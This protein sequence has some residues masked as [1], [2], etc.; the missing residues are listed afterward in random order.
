VLAEPPLVVQVRG[1]HDRLV[2][3]EDSRDLEGMPTSAQMAV[4]RATHDDV[5]AV[6]DEPEDYPGERYNILRDVIIGNVEPTDPPALPPSERAVTAVAFLLHGIRAGIG[7]WVTRLGGKLQGPGANVLV[8]PSYGY[9]S[10]YNFAI[11][12]GHRCMTD[13][14]HEPVAPDPAEQA[15]T[16]LTLG[17]GSMSPGSY[18]RSSIASDVRVLAVEAFDEPVQA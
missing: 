15:A 9:L 8:A 6:E 2:E 3:R 14:R 10:A 1:G 16:A 11:P 5:M 4:P 17:R 18:T 7:T 13:N 12:F